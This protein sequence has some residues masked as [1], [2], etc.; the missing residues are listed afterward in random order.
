MIGS[1]V[2]NFR[3][4]AKL[5]EG[6]MGVVYVGEHQMIGQKVAIKVL[7]HELSQNQDVVARFFNEARAAALLKH[8]GLI[9][10]F[11]FGYTTS[12]SAYIAMELLDGESLAARL[13][14]ERR[15]PQ[16]DLVH[17]GRQI[18]GA[19]GAAH[20]KGIVHRDLKPDNVFLVPDADVMGGKR[21]K[22]L[23]FGIA[24]LAHSGPGAA[25]T[26]TG[27][28]IGT[29]MYMSPEQ[30]R[31][32]G[33]VD[34]R[35]DIYAL[36]CILFEMACGRPPFVAEG[37][38][39]L[40]A[41]Q[42]FQP[43]PAPRSFEPALSTALEA[44]ILRAL[45]KKPEERQQSMDQ[46]KGELDSASAGKFSTGPHGRAPVQIPPTLAQPPVAPIAPT[47]AAPSSDVPPTRQPPQTTLGRAAAEVV[48][49][50]QLTPRRNGV[51]V[52]LAVIV[53]LGGTGAV[54][55]LRGSS[56]KPSA[57]PVV[58]SA[59]D[60]SVTAK[61]R[62]PDPSPPPPFSVTIKSVATPTKFAAKNGTLSPNSDHKLVVIDAEIAFAQCDQ[63]PV[64]ATPSKFA[65]PWAPKGPLEK[66]IAVC[67][68]KNPGDCVVSSVAI[69]KGSAPT[70][71]ENSALV[72]TA[73]AFLTLPDGHRIVSVGGK[74]DKQSCGSCELITKTRCE[75]ARGSN[76]YSFVFIVP[77]DSDVDAGTFDLEDVKTPLSAQ[78]ATRP[79]PV[80]T[81]VSV[82]PTVGTGAPV[83]AATEVAAVSTAKQGSGESVRAASAGGTGGGRTTRKA[84][85]MAGS[86]EVRGS[87]DKEII[88]R[89]IRRH[90]NEVKFCYEQAVKENPTLKGRVV[91][92]F[93]IAATGQVVASTVAQSTM[94]SGTVDNCIAGAVRRWEFPKP[95]GGGIVIVSY[96][97]VL[98]Q[99]ESEAPAATRG[100]TPRSEESSK[101]D[102]EGGSTGSLSAEQIRRVVRS[103]TAAV[104]FC[105][106]KEL[107]RSPGLSGG[108]KVRFT[109]GT[110]GAV[111]ASSMGE[112]TLNNAQ[113]EGCILRQ[114]KMWVFP[115]P[116]GGSV[117]VA[118]PFLFKTAGGQ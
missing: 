4:V 55:A 9:N 45:A 7:L 97:F 21:I 25:K 33:Q 11:D 93:T 88:Q 92:Q 114:V 100:G 110:D 14:R 28:I 2:G 13:Q 31:G 63:P 34:H 98:A 39:E 91:V 85:V 64:I 66:E 84:N 8:P 96:P 3:I 73:R 1:I 86:A 51:L 69:K 71:P 56:E 111:T 81:T 101:S 67:S 83:P 36:G 12:G 53:V 52:G 44:L 113:V 76:P 19:V 42:M 5:G 62:Q 41:M 47:L 57:P 18:A 70:T 99:S 68:L 29:P 43:P 59:P 90:I 72:T 102:S 40:L 118:Y 89:I 74:S 79:A 109:I 94:N 16:E 87:L 117:S 115:K 32:S 37:L 23:D 104:Q 60:A 27:S 54:F 35:T 46:L 82:P 95:Q 6:G 103:H 65:P 61:V 49:V 112:S 77:S 17:I 107:Q 38:G 75:T 78:Q 20:A 22:V 15:L 26:R 58:Q 105:Y 116:E 48:P 24:K 80:A 106:E 10:V 30:C 50:P 108:V